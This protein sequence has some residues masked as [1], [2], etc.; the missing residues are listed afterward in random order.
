MKPDFGPATLPTVIPVFPLA[1]ALVLPRAS[2]PLNIFEP[3]YLAMVRD[4]MANSRMIGMVQPR[5]EGSAPELFSVGGL[6]RITQFAEADDGRF[7]IVLTGVCRFRIVRELSVTTPYRQ[8]EADYTPFI[9]DWSEGSTLGQAERAE[10]EASLRSYLDA[11]GMAAD[12]DAVAS[13]DNESLVNTLAGVCPFDIAEKQALLEA[14]DLH[15]RASTLAMLMAF[16]SDGG[17]GHDGRT[18]H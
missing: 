3:R 13:A 12:W 2:L 6:G 18:V 15:Q 14:P 10:L 11:Q 16:S 8:V 4:A 7:L 9:D 17:D 1:G 5:G